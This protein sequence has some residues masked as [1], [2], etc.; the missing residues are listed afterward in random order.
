MKKTVS[1]LLALILCLGSCIALSSCSNSNG[2]HKIG[3]VQLVEHPALDAATEGFKK[4]IIDEL[5]EDAVTFDYQNAQNDANTCS[6]IVNQFVSNKV[7][8]IMANATPALQ[9]AAAATSEIPILG[10]SVTEY[11]VAL[12]L[13]NF[14]GTVGGNISGTSDLAPLDKQA[15]MITEWV[16]NAKKVGLLYCSK[17]ANSQYQVDV[18]KAELEK[19][20]ITATPYPFT[21]SN[22]LAQI[23]TTAADNNDVIYV[24]TDNTVAENTG[25]IDNIC[26]PKKI[27]VIAGEEGICKGC[28]IATLSISYYDLGYATGKMAVKILKGE[29]D[30]ATMPI[31]Y[32]ETQTPKYN[33]QI[34][35][36]LGITPLA[37]YTAIE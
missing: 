20:G 31:G 24:P 16:P 13:K 28:G 37:G 4:A 26:A 10:T 9:A 35:D 8:L 18:V 23:C 6:T 17:E 7:D 30:I 19:K 11:G 15:A 34:C 14:N 12:E 3:I 36:A 5:G 29:A 2:K 33:K 22:D 27:P 1:I 25:I 32:A 21:D